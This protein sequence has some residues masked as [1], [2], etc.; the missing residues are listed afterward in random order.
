MS[1]DLENEIPG[2]TSMHVNCSVLSDKQN[3]SHS[4]RN[5]K[6]KSKIVKYALAFEANEKTIAPCAGVA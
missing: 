2:A 6:F 4:E 1:L 3:A 5:V